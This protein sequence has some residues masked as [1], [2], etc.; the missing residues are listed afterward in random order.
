M[1]Q[2]RL[3]MIAA[4]LSCGMVPVMAQDAPE[5]FSVATLNVD[6]LP[7]KLLVVKINPDGPGDG[8]SA[9]I[10][11]YLLQK[12]YDLMFLQEDFN[13]H[14]VISVFLEDDYMMDEW[15]GDVE[16]EGHSIDYLHLQNHRFEC[17][18]LMTCWKNDLTVTPAPRVP[19]QQNFGKFS[20]ANDEII[21][22][23]FRRYEVTLRDGTRIVCYNIH[24]D[25][26]DD[27]DE[28]N[29][30][31][32]KDKA[33]RMAQLAQLKADVMSQLDI[34]P[35]II[36]G[37]LNSFYG[38]DA[39]K[40]EF[41]DAINDSG[42][43]T[44]SD[45]WVELQNGGN[46]PTDKAQGEEA[47]EMLDKILYI[48]PATGGK[49]QPIAFTVDKEGYTYDEKPLGDHYPLAATFQVTAKTTGINA[50][51]NEQPAANSEYFNLKGQRITKPQGGIY[52][53][54]Q[55]DKANKR[56]IK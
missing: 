36:L 14:S 44:I 56:I 13:F 6:G 18:G 37:D 47:G 38:R 8:G 30:N 19:W 22:K 48:N 52:I 21:T 3:W 46:Y 7:H 34:R 43:G 1:K 17:D 23:G 49:I 53:E 54:R 35:I 15:S 9:R 16:V 27:W 5:E 25:A 29:Q 39:L 51:V 55:G 26:T 4:I 40:T 41:I 28:E 33:A 42:L 12:N 50:V 20:H 45:V 31:D 32:A 24:M 10:G 2:I 11:K